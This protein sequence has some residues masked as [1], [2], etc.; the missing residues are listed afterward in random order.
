MN[1]FQIR[2]GRIEAP[3]TASARNTPSTIV[4][5]R[6]HADRVYGVID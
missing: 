4:S 1:I 6:T 3:N 5:N 2:I